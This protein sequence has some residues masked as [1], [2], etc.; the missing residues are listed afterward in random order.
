MASLQKGSN[1]TF[2]ESTHVSSDMHGPIVQ[3]VWCLIIQIEVQLWMQSVPTIGAA[4]GFPAA[5]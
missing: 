3:D 2:E 1:K 4:H 5:C